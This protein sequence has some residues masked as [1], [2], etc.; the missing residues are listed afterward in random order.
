MVHLVSALDGWRFCP[1]CAE[2]TVRIEDRAECRACGYVAYANAVPGTEAVCLDEQG[3]VLLGRRAFD[4]GKDLWDLPG[5]FLHE[6]ELPLD[7]LLR[8]V[9]E[10]TGLEIEPLDFLGFWLEPYESRFVLCL[11][12]TARATGEGRAADDL[13][14]LRWFEPH[15]LPPPGELAFTHYPA[16]LSLAVGYQ[17]S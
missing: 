8:E 15:E 9:R 17:H 16:V 7:G 14:E 10:E 6:Q 12:W 1:I 13:V 2:A 5:G 4:P 3:R 11:A